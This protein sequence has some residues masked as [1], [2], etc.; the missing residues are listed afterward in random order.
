MF[1]LLTAVKLTL[2]MSDSLIAYV[3]FSLQKDRQ[4]H[5]KEWE[6]SS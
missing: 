4:I 2:I 5:S 6:T 1:W 3:D